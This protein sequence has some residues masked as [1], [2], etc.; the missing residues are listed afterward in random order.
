VLV[1]DTEDAP[2]PIV[3]TEVLAALAVR[4]K[5]PVFTVRAVVKVALVTVAALPVMLP[6]MGLV[7][8]RLVSVPTLV[9]E[10]VTTDE[11]NVVPVNVPA[12]AVTVMSAD[13]LND[14]PLMFLA[15]CNVVAVE[16]LPVRA[17]ANVVAVIVAVLGLTVNP[18]LVL[19]GWLPVAVLE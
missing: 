19:S 14:T 18:A 12:A 4:V 11:F 1:P 17:P 13:P 6:A 10:D 9:R 5:V 3:R 8:V 2:A 7:T 16:A 15:V